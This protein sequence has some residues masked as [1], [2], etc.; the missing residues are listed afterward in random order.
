ML[1]SASKNTA[2]KQPWRLLTSETFEYIDTHFNS[3][4]TA[5]KFLTI[6]STLDSIHDSGDVLDFLNPDCEKIFSLKKVKKLE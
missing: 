4:N 6:Q 1:C 3:D 5:L 2:T